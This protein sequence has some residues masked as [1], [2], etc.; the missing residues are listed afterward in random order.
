MFHRLR[1]AH[2]LVLMYLL[3]FVSVAV[4]AYSLIVE[5]KIAINFAQKEQRGIAYVAVVRDVLL[6]VI[7]TEGRSD[8]DAVLLDQAAALEA[9]ER[10]YGGE[11]DAS[12]LTQRLATLLRQLSVRNGGDLAIQRALRAETMMAARELISRIGD[13]SNLI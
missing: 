10:R 6:A 2:R 12:A 7:E 8:Q 5:K 4:L 1:L 9:A 11:M 13:Q 3:S